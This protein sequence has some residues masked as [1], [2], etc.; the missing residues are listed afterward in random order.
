MLSRGSSPVPKRAC[1]ALGCE[2]AGIRPIEIKA[3]MIFGRK[4]DWQDQYDEKYVRRADRTERTAERRNWLHMLSIGI[5]GLFLICVVGVVGGQAMFEKT[6]TM[7]ATP[8]GAVWVASILLAYF[9]LLHGKTWPALV[10]LACW[11]V[12]SIFGNSF[13]ANELARRL[14]RPFLE[15]DP[16]DESQVYDVVFVLGGGTSTTLRGRAQTSTHGDRV[17]LAARMFHLG[18][19]KSIVT[20]GFQERRSSQQDL[21]PFQEATEIL[22]QLKIP[23]RNLASIPGKNTRQ[24][25]QNAA[26]YIEQ[27]GLQDAKM[28]VISSAWHLRRVVRLAATNHIRIDPIP[29]DFMTGHFVVG[30]GLLIP[31]AENL[32]KTTLV[33]KEHLARLVGR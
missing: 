7:L 2:L 26:S 25:I 6:L 1:Q 29:S 22:S 8:V 4:R 17:V 21:H 24:E 16:L 27:M 20:T 19:A 9:S 10:G 31:S 18:K 15:Q 3:Q 23:E 30:P 32:H 12:L 5:A 13:I 33:L 14:E 11:L 28:G